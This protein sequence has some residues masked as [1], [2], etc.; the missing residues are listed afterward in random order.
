MY[1]ARFAIQHLRYRPIPRQYKD[2]DQ[3]ISM[4]K[5]I[6]SISFGVCIE[7]VKTFVKVALNAE[8]NRLAI[9]EDQDDET[10]QHS[11]KRPKLLK[12]KRK[13]PFPPHASTTH[14]T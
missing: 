13:K 2:L 6:A 4:A 7:D 5:R 9:S 3:A 1:S 8:L 14:H 10:M 11:E 12:K